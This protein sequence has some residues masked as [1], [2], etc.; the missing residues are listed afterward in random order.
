MSAAFSGLQPFLQPYADA[1]YAVAVRYGLQPRVTSV[2]RSI[3][4]QRILYERYKSG[5]SKYPAAAP[6]RSLHNYGH[7]FDLVVS[8][9]EGQRWLGAVWEYWGGRWG[10]RF[11]DE[12]HF[13]SGAT[14]T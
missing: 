4:E 7:A 10:G 13:D 3:S 12:V 2:F 5:A 14:I 8:S 11:N 6:G 9:P 1:L